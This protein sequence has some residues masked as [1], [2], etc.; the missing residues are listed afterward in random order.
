MTDTRKIASSPSMGVASD[1]IRLWAGR[2]SGKPC[3]FCGKAIP[4]EDVQYD[5]EV[6][7]E[8]VTATQASPGRILSFH[9]RCYDQWRAALDEAD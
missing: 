5:V 8:L 3:K 7:E 1:A 6:T 9:L 2:G 4:A